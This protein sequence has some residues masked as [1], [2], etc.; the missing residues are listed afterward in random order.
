MDHG[1]TSRLIDGFLAQLDEYR[2]L[3]GHDPQANPV[4]LVAYDISR[5]LEAGQLTA[6]D[7]A[8]MTKQLADRAFLE[9]A[10]RMRA[11]LPFARKGDAL[12]AFEQFVAASAVSAD[13]G[14]VAFEQ[15]CLRWQRPCYGVVLTAHPTFSMSRPLYEILAGLVAAQDEPLQAPAE[16]SQLDHAPDAAV[17][18]DAEHEDAQ[19]ALAQLQAA[20]RALIHCVLKVARQT[21][22][23]RWS[24]LTPQLA[25]LACWVGYDLDGRTDIT[26]SHSIL[27]RLRE[28]ATQ[29]ARYATAV[30]RD[31]GRAPHIAAA[32]SQL[33]ER[34]ARAAASAA[35]DVQAF[36]GDL[37]G[38]DAFVAA[39]NKLTDEDP[40][41]LTSRA[42]IL[43]LIAE[44]LQIADEEELRAEL[45]ILRSEV[46]LYGLGTSHIH[47]RINAAQ[48]ANALRVQLDWPEGRALEGRLALEELDRLCAAV[49]PASIN[50]GSVHLERTTA[51][52]QMMLVAQML[53]HVDADTPI[54]FLIAECE[55]PVT[56]L[57]MVYFAKLFGVAGKVD[58]S[59]LFETPN[60]LQRGGRLIAQALDMPAFA[61]YVHGR[62]RISVQTGFS[63][64]GRFIG[65]IPAALAVERL[66]VLLA[67][68]LGER[69]LTDIEALIFD[70]HGESLGRGAHPGGLRERLLYLM[71]PWARSRFQAAGIP[72]K[73]ETSFQGGDGFVFFAREDLATITL[74]GLL[75]VEGESY[76]ME[77]ED[78]LFYRDIAF[79]WDFYT[80]LSAYHQD[81][82]HN[83]NYAG[84]LSTFGPNLL[85]KTGS[86][87]TKRQFDSG[88]RG[89]RADL[90]LIRAIPHNAILQQLGY[91]A[92][93]VAG[94]GSFARLEFDRLAEL[95]RTSPRAR[96]LIAMAA[97]AKRQ[98]SLTSLAAYGGI[99]D[100]GFW[101]ARA[102]GGGADSRV[103]ACLAVADL[104]TGRERYTV[105]ARLQHRL[106][107]DALFLHALLDDLEL[108]GGQASDAPRRE[109]Y[110]MHAIRLALIM[111]LLLLA[112]RLPNFAAQNDF[113]RDNLLELVL[114]MRIPEAVALLRE[115]FPLVDAADNGLNLHEPADYGSDRASGYPQIHARYIRPMEQVY[116]ILR[117]SGVGLSH[118][119]GAHG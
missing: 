43:D 30:P 93:V 105:F 42:A 106:R 11:Y 90:S 52:R 114:A 63:D 16:L 113:S 36:A 97:F 50:F 19:H 58:I 8:A 32:L 94:I 69:G 34:L 101:V 79:S 4:K 119:F 24:E 81:L 10:E 7:L 27:L 116:K 60:A 49:E 17:T 117:D 14:P 80:A 12:A 108:D 76:R 74:S 51:K 83:E 13:G 28:K 62:K 99:L 66:H 39:A 23:E 111:H 67:R 77:E 84:A 2:G 5:Q 48:V 3:L 86:R 31:A 82:F 35:E 57:G 98:S 107:K 22:R 1:N 25:S 29:L 33:R 15:F 44:V 109:L 53:K 110:L 21:Y 6:G 78:D 91:A 9:R 102:Y 89:L 115:T 46:M 65:Q 85:H 59:P 38:H 40:R 47:L 55:E 118:H 37:T 88:K 92:N 26:W 61:D 103:N 68:A 100:A 20:Q 95:F 71:S 87:E 112:A 45:V 73:H 18:L 41:R 96:M 75:L 104:L 64:A 54:R 56:L 70:T 72:L